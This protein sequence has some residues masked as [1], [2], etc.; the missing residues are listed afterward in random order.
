MKR[1]FLGQ[2]ECRMIYAYL[3]VSTDRQSVENQRHELLRFANDQH[4]LIETWVEETISS[5]K[6]LDERKLSTLLASL[7]P[8]NIL[9][10]SELSRLGRSLFEIMSI[11]H[12]LMEREVHVL[13]VK[14]R[15]ELGN[16]ISAKVLAFAFG[17]SAE[18]ERSLISAR[19]KEGLARRKAEGKQLGRPVG[20]RSRQGKL[21]GKEAD[22]ERLLAAK[23]PQA[24]IARLIGVH[25]H[26]I[27]NY[28]RQKKKR[29]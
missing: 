2:G 12:I 14:E 23:V 11:L 9:I 13:T 7:H 16:T 26:T 15:Y 5:T 3:R 25:R 29:S 8:G 22:I 24:A 10:I 18:I 1:L 27:E 20:S 4:L 6:S 19:T 28:V 21:T 17:L